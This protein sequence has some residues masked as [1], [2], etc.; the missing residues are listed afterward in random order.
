VTIK[1]R[2]S[3]AF[4]V[5]LLIA[6]AAIG[7]AVVRQTRQSLV[8]QIDD[9][10]RAQGARPPGGAQPADDPAQSDEDRF[11]STAELV[12]ARDGSVLRAQPAGFP[13]EPEPLPAVPAV[14]TREFKSHLDEVVTLPAEEGDVD[15]RVLAHSLGGGNRFL[16]LAAPLSEVDDAVSDLVRTILVTAAIIVAVG[17]ALAWW[18]VRRGLRPVDRMVDT[19]SAIA[20]GDMSQRIDHEDDGTE[21]GRLATAL[22]EM[23]T[24]LEAAFAERAASQ[25]RLEQFVADASH[26]LRTPVAAVRGYAELYRRGGIADDAAL[27][28]AMA[29]IESE[30]ERMGRLVDDLLLLARLDQHQPLDRA[31]VDVAQLARDAVSDAQ[32]VDPD[33]TFTLDGEETLVVDGDERRL[34][35]V[36][37]NLLANARVHTP[38]GTPV[39]VSIGIDNGTG[40]ISVADEGPGIDEGH[41]ARIFERFYRADKS[42]ARV[43]GGAGLGLSIVAGVVGAL[44]GTVDVASGA[45]GRGAVFTV[46]LPL[47]PPPG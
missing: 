4:V 3:I 32:A 2:L 37:A 24:Q 22:D 30:S 6:V 19:A 25:A 26:E 27:E 29:R 34:R 38:A 23:L 43:S 21:L 5:L 41:R 14:E 46:R 16:V 20:A 40:R 33:R 15:Y 36:F 13:D 17:A 45:D 35:Q 28:K 8:D 31:P 47:A 18:I 10:L 39:H 9:R 12:L 44:G 11:R 7:G 42:R 1:A